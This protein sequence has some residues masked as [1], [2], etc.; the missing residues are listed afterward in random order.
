MDK[1]AVK[2]VFSNQDGPHEN[3]T[4]W[5][6]RYVNT[7]YLRPIAEHTRKAFLEVETFVKKRACPIVLDSGCGTGRSTQV[8][9]QKFPECT[10][11]GIDKS[12]VRL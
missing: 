1:N 9:A 7:Q 10:V 8:L 3:L 12:E 5:V 2:K 11:I 4:E 6:M